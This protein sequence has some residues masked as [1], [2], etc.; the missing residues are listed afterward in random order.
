MKYSINQSNKHIHK[1]SH[2]DTLALTEGLK[3]VHKIQQYFW[4]HPDGSY[5]ICYWTL[6]I[7]QWQHNT[8]L[9]PQLGVTLP[10]MNKITE[11]GSNV[12]VRVNIANRRGLKWKRI[13]WVSRPAIT[14][15]REMQMY[16]CSRCFAHK[17]HWGGIVHLLLHSSQFLGSA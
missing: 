7:Y 9:T 4:R 5:M 8:H 15:A 1:V 13:Y 17:S 14:T 3:M 10:L 12:N 16:D 11:N 2:P 6:L